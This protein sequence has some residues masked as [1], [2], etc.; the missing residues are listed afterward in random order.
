[1]NKVLVTAFIASMFFLISCG[2]NTPEN[3]ADVLPTGTT[4]STGTF[5]SNGHTTSGTVKVVVDATNKKF[6]V[7]ENFRTDNAP[8][9]RVRLSPNNSG[10]PYEEIGALKA[11]NGNFSYELSATVNHTSNNRVLIWC[12][13][14]SVLFGNAILQ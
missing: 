8:D 9:L 12:R 4:L 7:F 6:L 1:M 13:P 14:F 10:S 11:V 2:K 5:T 3:A